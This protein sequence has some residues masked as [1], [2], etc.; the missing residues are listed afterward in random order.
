MSVSARALAPPLCVTL[1][2]ALIRNDLLL[3]SLLQLLK[4]SPLY[5]FRTPLW[6]V[7]GKAV[8][9]A[10]I[11]ARVRIDPATLTYDKQFLAWLKG[12]H[13]AGRELWLC[14][15]ANEKFA[16]AVAEHLGIFAGVIASDAR[17]NLAGE[18]RAQ[19]AGP[20]RA[21]RPRCLRLLR[22]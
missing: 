18:R 16:R 12:E 3:E 14:S 13:A 21:I 7:R 2:G 8:L 20:H 5:L 9:K 17:V 1:D 22:Q 11:A 19:G 10:Q 15:A 4:R 6:L